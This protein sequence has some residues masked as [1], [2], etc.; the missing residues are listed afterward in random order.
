MGGILRHLEK[1]EGAEMIEWGPGDRPREVIRIFID[2]GY[3]RDSSFLR[4]CRISFLRRGNL[5]VALS[6]RIVGLIPK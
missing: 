1:G 3:F 4:I 6:H 2:P 5:F